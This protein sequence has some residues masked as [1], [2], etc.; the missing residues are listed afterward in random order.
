VGHLIERRDLK[1]ICAQGEEPV[2]ALDGGVRKTTEE[3]AH[4]VRE[5]L[6]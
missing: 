6:K 5:A 1:K 2:H 3:V 4:L